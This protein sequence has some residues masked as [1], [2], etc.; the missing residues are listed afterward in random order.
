[1]RTPTR[2]AA[3][4]GISSL[5][6]AALRI[7]GRDRRPPIRVGWV[8]A[9][10]LHG[11]TR[12]LSLLHT[13]VSMRITNTAFWIN[14]HSGRV[15]NELYR[16]GRRY[17]V[18]VFFKAMDERCRDEAARVKGRGGRVVF[19]ANVNYYEVWGD[20]EI[21]GTRPS[22]EQQRDAAAMTELAD[23]VVADSSYLLDV[24]RRVNPRAEWIPDNVD[25]HVYRGRRAHRQRP[26]T[27]IVWSGIAAKA[28]HLLEAADALADVRGAELVLVS[29]RPPDVMRDLGGALPCTYVRFSDREYAA[30][31]RRCDVIISPKRLVNAYEVAHTEYKITLGMAV[32]LP[33]VASPQQSYREAI[34][35]RGGGVI[36][37]STAE[38]RE[39]LERLV[40]DPGLRADLG[41]RARLTV[42]ER[43]AT[44][45]VARR[46]LEVIESVAS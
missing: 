4:A 39:A 8:A 35:A 21:E 16:P 30:T 25:L 22:P 11:G 29:D 7:R 5:R 19:D 15:R 12:R 28:A 24:V 45:V 32:G 10:T 44:P 40:R 34:D 41:E 43:Y 33:A 26:L 17:D 42:R 31:L 23:R 14:A 18:V 46:Y 2:R 20:Y 36:A 6:G 37:A 9:D 13:P 3:Q 1:V 38:W 27:R